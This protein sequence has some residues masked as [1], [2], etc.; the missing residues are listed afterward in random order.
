MVPSDTLTTASFEPP[1]QFD[2]LVHFKKGTKLMKIY[3]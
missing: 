1:F 2:F 3:D